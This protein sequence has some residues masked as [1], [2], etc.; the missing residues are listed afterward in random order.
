MLTTIVSECKRH[1]TFWKYENLYKTQ[2]KMQ[3]EWRFFHTKMAGI[4]GT[5]DYVNGIST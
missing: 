3:K 1:T 4:Y 2:I 5:M